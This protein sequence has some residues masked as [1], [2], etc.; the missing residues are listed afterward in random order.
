MRTIEEMK[1]WRTTLVS[2][3]GAFM[4][5]TPTVTHAGD[6]VGFVELYEGPASGGSIK[7]D[8]DVL[9]LEA[10][11]VLQAGDQV[12]VTAPDGK[13]VLNLG[14]AQQTTITLKESPYTIPAPGEGADVVDNVFSDALSAISFWQKA[15]PGFVVGAVSRGDDQGEL[16]APLLEGYS[17]RLVS[18][19]RLFFLAWAGGTPPF[20]LT[21]SSMTDGPVLAQNGLEKTSIEPVELQL[22]PGGYHILLKDAQGAKREYVFDVV[23][24]S[25]LPENLKTSAPLNLDA[26]AMALAEAGALMQAETGDWM[27]EA[28][29]R[30]ASKAKKYGPVGRVVEALIVGE[31]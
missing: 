26:V 21:V 25:E 8:K 20:D 7:R 31:Y 10:L 22:V 30:L 2:L 19:T 29:Q 1:S 5:L 14:E 13:A 17:P 23:S 9:P 27:F 15:R 6:E 4:L 16:R 18:G 11:A 3:I 28:Y 24:E 12:L